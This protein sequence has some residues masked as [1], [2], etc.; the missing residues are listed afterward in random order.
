ME[1]KIARAL[2][3]LSYAAF[4]AA[5]FLPMRASRAQQ[6][7]APRR[8][9][10][11]TA[12]GERFVDSVLTT[13]SLEEKL[14]QLTQVSGQGTPTGPKV[15]TGGEDDIRS[16]RAGS[17]LG[18]FG[19]AYTRQLQKVAV[20][21]SKHHI[22]LLFSFDV[23]HGF[24][25]IFP[26]P[27]A[28]ASSWDPAL[29]SKGAAVAADEATSAGIHWTFAPMVDIARDPRW[30][31]IVEGSGEDPFLGAVLGAACVHGFQGTD[32]TSKRTLL[33]TAKHF[34]AYGAAEGGRDYNVAEVT[35]QTLFDVYLPPFQAAV[36]AGA[37]SVM[38]SFNEIGGTPMHANGAL[39]NGVLRRRW[40]WDGVL[41]SDYTGVM[42]LMPHGATAAAAEAGRRAIRAGVDIDMVSEIY[43]KS[44]PEEVRAGRVSMAMVDSAVRRVLLAASKC[45][46]L[47]P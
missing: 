12:N 3:I 38:A 36:D 13:L 27:L 28:E 34:V 10:N 26:V 8:F 15:Q 20:E 46:S 35:P 18:V 41:V 21:E 33:A 22:P 32:F 30:G 9:P 39:I 24:R 2:R 43:V 44:L 1:P 4:L 37:W 42:E 16:G 5:S 6:A 14:G 19:A 25:T 29:V 45:R 23:I 7:I 11:I 17:F 31:R 40:G 47:K